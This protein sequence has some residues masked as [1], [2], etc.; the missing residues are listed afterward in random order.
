MSV[1]GPRPVPM[2]Y[3]E[4]MSPAQRRRF[5]MRPGVTGLAQVSGRHKLTWSQ[6]VE[7]DV[8]YVDR[9]SLLLDLKILARTIGTI[10]D[11]ETLTERGDPGKVD[12]G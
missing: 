11:R 12:L 8:E 9:F 10:F 3:A 7:F 2:D 5:A 4:R 6:R 1:V